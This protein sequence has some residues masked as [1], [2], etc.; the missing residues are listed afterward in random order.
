MGKTVS[1][2]E[3]GVTDWHL[4][5]K[6]LPSRQKDMME[7]NEGLPLSSFGAS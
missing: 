2:V 5:H 4:V 1:C 7:R 3:F 6:I